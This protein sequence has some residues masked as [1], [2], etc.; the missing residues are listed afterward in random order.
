MPEIMIS[1][2]MIV[3]DE[4]AIIEPTLKQIKEFMKQHPGET[5]LVIVDGGSK[6][7]TLEICKKYTDNIHERKF[8]GDFATHKNYMNN[9]CHGQWIVNID[10]DELMGEGLFTYL[11]GIVTDESNMNIDLL[12][13]P[14]VNKVTGLTNDHIHIWQ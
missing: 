4:E 5:E 12:Y 6:D 8:D 7:K 3:Q 9:R 11:W 13:V 1:F 2:A 14:R 10:A